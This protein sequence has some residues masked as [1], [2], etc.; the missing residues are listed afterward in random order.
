LTTST[1]PLL[2][3]RVGIRQH[4]V[5]MAESHELSVSHLPQSASLIMSVTGT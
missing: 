3:A 1:S 5:G 2:G 4:H